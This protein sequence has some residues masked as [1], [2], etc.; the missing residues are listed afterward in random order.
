VNDSI[1]TGRFTV[2]RAAYLRTMYAYNLLGP[3]LRLVLALVAAS[4]ATTAL[5]YRSVATG[6]LLGLVAFVPLGLIV[7]YFVARRNVYSSASRQVFD[8]PRVMTFSKEGIHLRTEDGV[9]SQMPWTHVV[10][11]VRRGGFTLLFTGK[12]V[13]LIVPDSAFS[14]PDLKTFSNLLEFRE[15]T[16]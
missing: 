14:A 5:G 1:V 12:I 13:H 16:R 10:K 8:D 4:A 7:R 9:E 3:T 2:D 11:V 6:F 15:P